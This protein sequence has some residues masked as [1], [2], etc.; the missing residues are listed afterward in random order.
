MVIILLA[1]LFLF[2]WAIVHGG[3]RHNDYFDE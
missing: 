1:I 3:T 2:V